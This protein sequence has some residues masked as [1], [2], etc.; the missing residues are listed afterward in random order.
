MR[1]LARRFTGLAA[2]GVIALAGACTVDDPPAPA[3]GTFEWTEYRDS[4][5]GVR[6]AVPD[7]YRPRVDG[8]GSAV[9]FESPRGIPVKLYWTTESEASGRGLWFG[10]SPAGEIRLD[11]VD[12]HLFAYSH[13]DGP[14]CSPMRSYVVPYRGKQLALE[15]RSSGDL[16]P[17]HR[18]ILESIE[19]TEAPQREEKT[20]SSPSESTAMTS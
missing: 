17:V 11:G 13:C 15:F 4:R 10:S 14:L 6:L 7:V 12:G 8:D 20:S 5:L 3:P 16:H 2:Y 1:G 18:R 19:F 9:F